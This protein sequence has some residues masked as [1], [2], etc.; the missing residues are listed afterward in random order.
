M[1][2]LLKMKGQNNNINYRYSFFYG[3]LQV[4]YK[5]IVILEDLEYLLL[6]NHIEAFTT[7]IF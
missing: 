3:S 7:T 5:N 6:T 1:Y 2:I 4:F